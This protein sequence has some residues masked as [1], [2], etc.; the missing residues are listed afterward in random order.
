ME[1]SNLK[2]FLNSEVNSVILTE[3]VIEYFGDAK[4]LRDYLEHLAHFPG[5]KNKVQ[6]RE[7]F[8]SSG[9]T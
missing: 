3:A 4:R 9:V 1:T 2:Y 7:S 5:K 6:R 8:A